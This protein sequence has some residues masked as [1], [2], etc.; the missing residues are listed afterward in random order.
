MHQP[1]CGG[2]AARFVVGTRYACLMP[3]NTRYTHEQIDA[4]R[5]AS[6]FIEL[7]IAARCLGSD[8]AWGIADRSLKS[9][10]IAALQ[11]MGVDTTELTG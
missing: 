8:W 7:E 6:N 11:R 1:V 3:M 5:D 10:R 9:L 2:L 4:V